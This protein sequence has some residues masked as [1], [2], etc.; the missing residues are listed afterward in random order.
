MKLNNNCLCVYSSIHLA[1]LIT[2]KEV[3]MKKPSQAAINKENARINREKRIAKRLI[4]AKAVL[5]M[6]KKRDKII[7]DN[8]DRL[9]LIKAART[10]LKADITAG[11][12]IFKELHKGKDINI[13]ISNPELAEKKNSE[14]LTNYQVQKLGDL[15]G[16]CVD[17]ISTNGGITAMTL[18]SIGIGVGYTGSPLMIAS[19]V[20]RDMAGK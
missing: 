9:I 10:Q 15:K 6:A 14:P 7:N 16:K 11:I 8:A 13:S 18:T 19:K 4:D 17:T 3:T 5:A 20:L 1:L 12:E 2:H